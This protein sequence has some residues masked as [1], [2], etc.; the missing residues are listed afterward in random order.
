MHLLL[1]KQTNKQRFKGLYFHLLLACLF[2]QNASGAAVVFSASEQIHR[3]RHVTDWIPDVKRRRRHEIVR[4]IVV[5]FFCALAAEHTGC[6][7]VEKKE[8]KRGGKRK[9]FIKFV[10]VRLKVSMNFTRPITVSIFQRITTRRFHQS[11]L[12]NFIKKTIHQRR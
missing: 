10:L 6:I 7:H 3:G 9:R 2:G 8:K 5:F 12:M 4:G 11:P 1:K